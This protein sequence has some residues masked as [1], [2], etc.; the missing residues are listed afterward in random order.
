MELFTQQELQAMLS[1]LN[2]IPLS[3]AEMLFAQGFFQRL[4]AFCQ[5]PRPEPEP[6]K[7]ED[8]PQ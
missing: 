5:P 2:R 6:E 1:L 7:K 4:T 3:P 8:K